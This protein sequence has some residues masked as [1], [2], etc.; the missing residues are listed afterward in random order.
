MGIH[1][2]FEGGG[3]DL[4][5]APQAHFHYFGNASDTEDAVMLIAFNA[6]TSGTGDDTGLAASLSAVP[7]DVLGVSPS[8]FSRLPCTT[9]RV[10]IVRRPGHEGDAA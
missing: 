4:V 7:A 8:L 9:E 3:G 5:L 1:D 6:S 2:A 10:V